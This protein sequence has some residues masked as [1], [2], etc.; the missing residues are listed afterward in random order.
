MQP[1][2]TSKATTEQASTP[3]AQDKSA[4]P[5]VLCDVICLVALMVPLEVE[6]ISNV[7]MQKNGRGISIFPTNPVNMPDPI[8]IGS[9][10]AGKHRPKV[11][12]MNL[13]I[14]AQCL[15]SGLDP[16]G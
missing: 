5:S 4:P 8:R 3:H 12:R 1:K 7:Q 6:E 14:L 9:G 2:T 11:G 10:S 13:G 15:A 16:F